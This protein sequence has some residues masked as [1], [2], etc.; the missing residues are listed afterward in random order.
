M[1]FAVIGLPA[2]QLSKM[3]RPC[4]AGCNK[5]IWR[6]VEWGMFGHH[7][8]AAGSKDA[9]TRGSVIHWARFYDPVVTLLTLGRAPAMREEAADL[10]AIQPG[11]SVLEVGCGT[12]Q[13][14]QRARARAGSS[15]LVCGIDPSAEM[16]R[17]AR[18][19]AQRAN[20]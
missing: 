11:E 17:V 1:L 5:L 6:S 3:R 4:L 10:A 14:T 19:K 12:G 9:G 18:E 15:G 7:D 20:L 16:I 2:P 13:L 8:H